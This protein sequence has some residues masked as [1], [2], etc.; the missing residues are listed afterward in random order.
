MA[1][2]NL[3]QADYYSGYV[4][5]YEGQRASGVRGRVKFGGFCAYGVWT[6]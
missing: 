2:C 1:C 3:L 6:L 5:G 4:F